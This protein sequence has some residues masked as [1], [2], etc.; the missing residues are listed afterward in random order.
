MSSSL[1]IENSAEKTK[2][3]QSYNNESYANSYPEITNF[4]SFLKKLAKINTIKSSDLDNYKEKYLNLLEK[5]QRSNILLITPLLL[6]LVFLLLFILLRKKIICYMKLPILS[7]NLILITN[8]LLLVFLMTIPF[9][10]SPLNK[11]LYVPLITGNSILI[12]VKNLLLPLLILIAPLVLL[13]N[14]LIFIFPFFP[15]HIILLYFSPPIFYPNIPY[16][17]IYIH[18][19]QDIL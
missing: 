19:T 18:V 10:L 4:T 2:V 13:S 14:F 5:K 12:P 8:M 15:L 11:F 16:S 17:T 1:V 7:L 9:I 6:F 3:L